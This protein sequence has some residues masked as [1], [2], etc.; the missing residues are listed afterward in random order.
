MDWYT[1][2]FD[3]VKFHT[4]RHGAYRGRMDWYTG[5][6]DVVKFH[7][8]RHRA[9]PVG[10]EVLQNSSIL[11]LLKIQALLVEFVKALK[12][13]L[14]QPLLVIWDGARSHHRLHAVLCGT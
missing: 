7:T 1:G 14:K 12:S 6:F 5:V 11:N 10:L 9:Q 8:K 4:K 3:V 2:V 13:H